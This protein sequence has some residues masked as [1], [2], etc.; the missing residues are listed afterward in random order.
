MSDSVESEWSGSFRSGRTSSFL[1]CKSECVPGDSSPATFRNSDAQTDPSISQHVRGPQNVA[2]DR[3]VKLKQ[4][5]RGLDAE[6]F[7][8][9][10]MEQLASLCDSQY[11]FVA[12]RIHDNEAAKGVE[13]RNPSLH[14]IAFYYN[15]GHGTVG[16]YRNR[17]FAGGNP[18]FHMDHGKACLIPENL[19]SFIS[20]DQDKLPFAAEG[21]LAV[22]LFSDTKYAAYLGLMW[23]GPGLQKRTLS[24]QFLQMILHS[25]EDLIVKR[26][27]DEAN[28]VKLDRSIR[29]AHT[30]SASQKMV[31]DTHLNLVQGHADFSSHALKPYARSLSHELRTPMQGIVGMLDVMHATVREAMLGKP[32]PT[33]GGVFQALKESIEMVQGLC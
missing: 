1:P 14:G 2:V 29:E 15:D 25:L 20:F 10:L 21:Y 17:S 5:L 11:A 27:A 19:G 26:I 32:P 9:Q 13:S 24:W 28:D 7:W 12:H 16:M 31:D 3:L 23:S 6:S 33:T 8:T 30:V 18:Q 22:P 4:G